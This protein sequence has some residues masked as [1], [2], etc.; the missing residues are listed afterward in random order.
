MTLVAVTFTNVDAGTPAVTTTVTN[1]P[2]LPPSE[3]SW[4]TRSRP[5]RDSRHRPVDHRVSG[6]VTRVT[7]PDSLAKAPDALVVN[8]TAQGTSLGAFGLGREDAPAPDS[9]D[10]PAD[11]PASLRRAVARSANPCGDPLPSFLSPRVRTARGADARGGSAAPCPR[12][13]AKER[14]GRWPKNNLADTGRA[15]LY[16]SEPSCSRR[17]CG[18]HNVSPRLHD[19]HLR[20]TRVRRCVTPPHVQLLWTWAITIRCP[21]GS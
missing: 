15:G 17:G 5:T 19:Q 3:G 21:A 10:V 6:T 13:P 7:V 11:P 16:G 8:C 4:T 20:D 9:L 14:R 18:D 1:R 12:P 2:A